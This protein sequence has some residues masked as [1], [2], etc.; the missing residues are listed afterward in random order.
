MKYVVL[1]PDGAADYPL[2]ELGGKTPLE[3]ANIPKMNW[4]AQNGVLGR[5]RTVPEGLEPGS[6]VA[7][8]SLLGYDP[9]KYY[10]GRGSLE[11][12]SQGIPLASDEF[13]FRCNLVTVDGDKMVDYSA[14][15]ISSEE[16]KPLIEAV[17]DKLG[18]SQ[19][20]FYPG[21]SYRH[22]LIVKGDFSQVVCA[23][24]HDI[25]GRPFDDYLPQGEG[26]ELLKKLMLASSKVLKDHPANQKRV[27]SGKREAN[28]I[29]L[30][31][32]GKAAQMPTFKEKYDLEGAVISAVD[33]IKGI[34]KCAGLE[35][36]EVEGA[37]GYFDT[38]YEGK[39]S[40][41]LGSL[42]KKD[43]VLVHVE[44]TDE[45]GH[46]GD[47]EE[48]IKALE[49]FDAKV[50]GGILKGLENYSNYKILIVPDHATPIAVRTHTSDMVPFA[51]YSSGEKEKSN[52]S[53]NEREAQASPV[54]LNE[55][56]QLMSL[57]VNDSL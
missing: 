9:R 37:T 18:G 8:L 45:A 57:F 26:A 5:V 42:T 29:W 47:I 40:A 41:A 52:R 19:V 16:A 31:G 1:V 13:A 36:I 35:V 50:V 56:H 2:D 23:P 55:G 33:L 20:R 27:A 7:I 15:H 53:F 12:A 51:A 38:N 30:W 11:A 10:T 46:I 6:D 21:V 28:M 14:G 24:P 3:V 32:G 49:N 43:F 54:Y 48:K 34:G 17:D 22:L 4:L 25:T 39:A 44:A